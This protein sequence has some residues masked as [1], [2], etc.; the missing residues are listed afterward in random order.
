[1]TAAEVLHKIID[2]LKH[3]TCNDKALH[4]IRSVICDYKDFDKYMD[5]VEGFDINE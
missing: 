5:G 4:K 3:E 2:V 1:M